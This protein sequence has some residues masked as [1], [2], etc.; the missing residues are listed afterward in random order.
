MKA[1]S[2]TAK[3][4]AGFSLLEMMVV[5]VIIGILATIVVI[6]VLPSQDRAMA[7]RARADIR[8]LEQAVELYR[9]QMLAYP[10]TEDG[11]EAL[12][13]GPSDTALAARFPQG[14]FV[15][16]LQTDP[17]G[18]PYQYLYP[19]ELGEFDIFTL[20]QDGRAGG[21]GLDAD[22]GNWGD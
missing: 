1:L 10:S 9:L 2:T 12:V 20:G 13:S 19:G 5:L 7:E 11:L 6:N 22:I 3:P 15:R 17:W 16:R 8:T 21:E 4:K 14:G 18:N